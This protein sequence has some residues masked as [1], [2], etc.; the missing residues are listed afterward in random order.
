MRSFS[1]ETLRCGGVMRAGLSKDAEVWG[2]E[3][4]WLESRRRGVEE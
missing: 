2:G 4:G 1:V 3:E